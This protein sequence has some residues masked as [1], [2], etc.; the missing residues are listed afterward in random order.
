[1]RNDEEWLSILWVAGLSW[2]GI[3][4]GVMWFFDLDDFART[5]IIVG[6]ILILIVGLIYL[7]DSQNKASEKERKERKEF[8]ERKLK[9]EE[10]KLKESSKYRKT[11]YHDR[12]KALYST[13]KEFKTEPVIRKEI[14]K[15]E[16]KTYK[17]RDLSKVGFKVIK[18]IKE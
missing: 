16:Q 9:L 7:I 14:K 8:A 11:E 3:T 18:K 15:S 1:M 10:A 6:I 5:G 17:S 4:K 2:Y 13:K 12:T